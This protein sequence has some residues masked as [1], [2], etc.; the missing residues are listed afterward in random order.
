[1]NLMWSSTNGWNVPLVA[2]PMGSPHLWRRYQ[3]LVL[4]YFRG[5]LPDAAEDLASAVWIDVAANLSAFHGIGGWLPRLDLHD[6]SS[7]PGRRASPP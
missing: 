2:T 1:M 5:R 6:R 4:R 7:P 3:P